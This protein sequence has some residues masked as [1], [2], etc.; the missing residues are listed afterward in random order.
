MTFFKLQVLYLY[1]TKHLFSFAMA[2]CIFNRNLRAVD[3]LPLL[4]ACAEHAAVYPVFIL[5]PR[6]IDKHQ[7][8][9]YSQACV[10]Y[11]ISCLNDLHR[12]MPLTIYRGAPADVVA[13]LIKKHGLTRKVYICADYTPYALERQAALAGVC[14]LVVVDDV[15]LVPPHQLKPYRKFSAYYAACQAYAV[16]KVD[17]RNVVPQL[18]KFAD[19]V[20]LPRTDTQPRALALQILHQNFKDYGD[21]KTTRL[22]HHMKFGVVSIREVYWAYHK[23]PMLI[24][25]IYF[26]EFYLH[27]MYHFKLDLAAM[28]PKYLKFPWRGD[29]AQLHAWQS[30]HTGVPFVDAGMRQL[31]RENFMHNRLRMIVASFLIKNLL[32]N[33]HEGERWFA[34]HLID[35]DYSSNTASWL[36][37]L[38]ANDS[39]MYTRIFNPMLQGKEHDKECVYIKEYVP[40]LRPVAPRDIHRWDEVAVRERYPDVHYPGPIIDLNKT[41]LAALEIYH[42]LLKN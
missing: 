17:A 10:D 27:E 4:R 16:P 7:N 38:G 12:V 31:A 13:H 34:Q 23:V 37:A 1:I 15:T 28:N 6:Q 29:K 9:Y 11:M 35:Y 26:R 41:R 42:A 40:E 8:P 14:E 22:S 20:A 3:N 39:T 30:G 2:L 18:K 25:Q 5:D 32:I 21:W 36:W 19:G 33:W 24:R